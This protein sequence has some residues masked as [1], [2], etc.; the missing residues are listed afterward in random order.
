M[1][2]GFGNYLI[3]ERCELEHA[4]VFIVFVDHRAIK[5]IKEGMEDCTIEKL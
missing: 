2:S 5:M 4:Y 1:L 3:K